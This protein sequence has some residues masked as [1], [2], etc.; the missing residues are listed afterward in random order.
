MAKLPV[1]DLVVLYPHAEQSPGS[2]QGASDPDAFA[3]RQTTWL[4]RALDPTEGL[5]A[6]G[7]C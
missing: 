6:G 4:Q 7:S 3:L 1:D 2:A 5:V